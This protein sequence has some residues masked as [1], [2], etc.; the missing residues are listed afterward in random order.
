MEALEAV[1]ADI[2]DQGVSE[3]VCLG[4]VVGY[5]P[6]PR[7]CLDRARQFSVVIQGNH[8]QALM[9]QMESSTFNYRAR[10]SLDW[11]RAQFSMLGQDRTENASRWDFLGSLQE[12]YATNGTLHVHGTPR[13]PVNEYLYPRDIYRPEK[14]EGI[15]SMID[16]VAFVGHTH[17]PG[18]WTE[19][20]VYLTPDE[21]NG[22]YRLG[23]KKVVINVGSVGQP[24]DTD[25]RA[26]YV[27]RDGDTVLF[28][29]VEYPVEKT[30]AKIRAISELDAFLAERLQEGR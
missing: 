1:L 21:V 18:V 15:F 17:V 7:E 16:W 10:S 29:R 6:N 9:V 20:M 19:D 11:T 8:E 14:L 22:R 25:T 13:D 5:G 26:S 24:R 30:V 28:R 3:I 4:D 2:E 23:S 12:T 27:L